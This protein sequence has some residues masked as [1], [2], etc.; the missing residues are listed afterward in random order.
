MDLI[1]L[2]DGKGGDFFLPYYFAENILEMIA[3][4]FRVRDDDL[5]LVSYPKSGTTWTKRILWLLANNGMEQD[6]I[7]DEIIPRIEAEEGLNNANN[8]D[9]P[10]YITSHLPYALMPRVSGSRAKYIY[11]ARNPKDCVVSGYHFYSNLMIYS[12]SWENYLSNFMQGVVPFGDWFTHVLDSY[13]ASLESEN[14]L[15]IKYEDMK[16]DLA[17][18]VATIARFLDASLEP[19]LLERIL[20]QSGFA[21]MAKNPHINHQWGE[22]KDNSPKMMRKGVVGDW[23]NH[24]TAEQNMVFDALYEE[25]VKNS[26]LQL[27]FDFV[28]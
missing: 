7:I 3:N 22:W 21:A 15:F 27:A 10:R 4:D 11:I 13:E 9:S 26:K 23:Q 20:E 2:P 28:Q 25:K 24:F 12:G 19:T 6:K 14:I 16:Q 17:A 5:F 1:K 18:V 8:L